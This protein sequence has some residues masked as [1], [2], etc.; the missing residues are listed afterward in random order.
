KIKKR[1][2]IVVDLLSE[3]VRENRELKDKLNIK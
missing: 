1:Y 2:D 3:V